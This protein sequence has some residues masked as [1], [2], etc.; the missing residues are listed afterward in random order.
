MQGFTLPTSKLSS[1]HTELMYKSPIP[2]KKHI[3][4]V[5]IIYTQ[6]Y[7]MLDTI[8]KAA[9]TCTHFKLTPTL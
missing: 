9:H 7:C 6:H 8:I 3:E 4:I 2:I 5:L 1:R